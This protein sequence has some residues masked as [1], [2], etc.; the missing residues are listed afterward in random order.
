MRR[1]HVQLE[2]ESGLPGLLFFNGAATGGSSDRFRL[3]VA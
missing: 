2:A 3:T 1:H